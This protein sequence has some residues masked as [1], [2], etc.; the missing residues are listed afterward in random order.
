MF[1]PRC[2]AEYRPGFTRCADCDVDLVDALPPEPEPAYVD[3][4][5]ILATFNPGDIALVKSILDAEA[6]AYYFHGEHFT[7]VRPL[8]DPARLM[9]RQDQA[10]TV[11]EL[12]SGLTLSH[13]AFSLPG[14][15][16]NGK[17]E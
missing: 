14:M 16:S 5:E 1:C 8:A 11:R 2:R 3:F 13:R 9:V 4:V 10:E 12:L 6:I 15:G 7:Y 17:P